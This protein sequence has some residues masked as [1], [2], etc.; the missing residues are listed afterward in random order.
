MVTVRSIVAPAASMNWIICQM[1]VHNA[2]LNGDLLEKVYMNI[3]QGTQNKEVTTNL[4]KKNERR[5]EE[6]GVTAV[7]SR[8]S[9]SAVAQRKYAL[10][11]IVEAGLGGA[12][13][14]STPLELNHM[15]TSE[16]YDK[17]TQSSNKDEN[18]KDA[19]PY[20]RLVGS[21]SISP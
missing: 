14:V 18:L 1:D 6:E 4:R 7:S 5:A 8:A 19:C 13:P 16:E 2:F 17:H 12:K 15:L 3:P 9:A 20:Q 11:L 21:C 10:E